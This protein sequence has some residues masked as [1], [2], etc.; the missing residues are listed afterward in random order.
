MFKLVDKD[1]K[2]PDD[3]FN[4]ARVYELE[5]CVGKII[6]KYGNIGRMK[7]RPDI[8]DRIAID[9]LLLVNDKECPFCKKQMS[10]KSSVKRHISNSCA[11]RK[12][13][14]MEDRQTEME[15]GFKNEIILQDN[16]YIKNASPNTKLRDIV[17]ISGAQGSGKSFWC[18]Q[19]INDFMKMFKDKPII[20][21]SRIEDDESFREL[22]K[23][24][25]MIP[26]DITDD[27]LIDNPIDPKTELANSLCVFDDYLQFDKEIKKSLKHTLSDIMLNG[28]D[29][30]NEGN[31]IYCLI[32]SHMLMDYQN[33]RDIL[34][35]ASMIVMF[36]HSGQVYHIRR[37]LKM[38]VGLSKQQIEKCLN[39]ESRWIACYKRAPNYVIHE[40][41][42][43]KV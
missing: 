41:G 7:G 26:L 10:C 20:L 25:K 14:E 22:I 43:F 40:A 16:Q 13:D 31:D 37:C 17:Y 1:V 5:S 34:N 32:T 18:R 35:E 29:Q 21:M 38:Y 24:K 39:L 28:R 12:V 3:C 19:Y 6:C 2:C 11:V 30:A 9:R 15:S 23:N 33:T 42:I 4:V 27:D 8:N 36:P